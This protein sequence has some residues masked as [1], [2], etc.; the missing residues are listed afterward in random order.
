M[1]LSITNFGMT[2]PSARL[3]SSHT[4]ARRE[5]DLP[6]LIEARAERAG[7]RQ[8][9]VAP[10]ASEA[11]AVARRDLAPSRREV[12]VPRKQRRVVVRAQVLPVLDDEAPLERRRDLAHRRDVRV[13]EDVLLDP[14]VD[15]QA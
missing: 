10:A 8:K 13:R 3:P 12:R 2:A 5:D 6:E 4:S 9:V 15:H 1:S 14:R 7:A 11:L